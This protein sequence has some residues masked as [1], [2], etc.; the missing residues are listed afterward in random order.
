MDRVFVA[1]EAWLDQPGL[2]EATIRRMTNE[3]ILIASLDR[4]G[5]LN[6]MTIGWGVFGWIWG[7]PM[8]EVLVR[9]SRYTYECIEHTRDYTVNVLPERIKDVPDFCGTVSGRDVDKMAALGLHALPSRHVRSGGVVEAD[10][11]FECTVVHYNDVQEPSFE[12]QI[13][14]NYYAGGDFHRVYFGQI[15]A[16]SVAP[17]FAR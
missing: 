8:F 15:M 6:P 16:V 1:A 3:G 5:K 13:V 4:A 11:V 9:P 17:R 12:E 2:A 10:I 14:A 7:R